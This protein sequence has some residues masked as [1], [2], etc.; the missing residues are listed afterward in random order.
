M[1]LRFHQELV[2]LLPSRHDLL[3]RPILPQLG[4]D[5]LQEVLAH[6]RVLPRL[7]LGEKEKNNKRIK[8]DF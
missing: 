6:H 5:A 2:R 3:R 4:P 8:W 1:G 7:D